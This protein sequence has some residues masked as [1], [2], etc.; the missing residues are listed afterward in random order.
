MRNFDKFLEG[1]GKEAWET[2]KFVADKFL[3]GYKAPHYRQ[4]GEKVLEAY[5]MMGCNMSLK[6]HFL[7]NHLDFSPANRRDVSDE[8]VGRFHHDISAQEKCYQRKENLPVLAGYAGSLREKF[9]M[10]TRENKVEINSE[11]VKYR[12]KYSIYIT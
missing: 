8:H 9:Q 7:H 6:I 3:G 12:Y 5:R 11:Y 4:L 10:H 1:I 2:P